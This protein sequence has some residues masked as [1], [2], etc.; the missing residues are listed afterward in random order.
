MAVDGLAPIGMDQLEADLK[1]NIDTLNEDAQTLK[2]DMAMVDNKIAEAISDANAI[3]ITND[4]F[5]E[6]S[7]S[8]WPFIQGLIPQGAIAPGAVGAG[9]LA[10]F[11]LTARKFN[12]DRHRLY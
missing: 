9:D 6:D 4:R 2:D 11:V 3:P 1:V 7:L 5:T 10:D 8:I 12:D